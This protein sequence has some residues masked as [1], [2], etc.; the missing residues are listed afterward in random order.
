MNDTLFAK[1][2]EDAIA[3]AKNDPKYFTHVK[4]VGKCQCGEN[5]SIDYYDK[6][7]EWLGAITECE[8]CFNQYTDKQAVLYGK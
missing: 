8:A 5:R 3:F 7:W 6:D 2:L 4:L 1:T